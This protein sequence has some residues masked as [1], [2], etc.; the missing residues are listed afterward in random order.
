MNKII[1]IGHLARDI[2]LR[3]TPTGIAVG[4][5]SIAVNTNY[6][7][8]NGEKKQEACF[9]E[10]SA[11]GKSAE[12]MNQYLSKGKKVLVEGRLKF[13][14]WE[15]DG[16]KHSKHSVL[17]ESF[18]FLESKEKDDSENSYSAPTPQAPRE[19]KPEQQALEIDD[20]S[21]PF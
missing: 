13:D 19:Q 12:I 9:I 1:L 8:K 20:D 5:S 6:K 7:D 10:I 21:I 2:E 11:F 17:V 3:Y 4:N 14:M 16:T 18:E 15:K